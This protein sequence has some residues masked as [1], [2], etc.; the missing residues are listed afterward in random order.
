MRRFLIAAM[1]GAP[2][3]IAGPAVAAVGE[4]E[5]A[6]QDG[7][8]A[9]SA[10]G[11]SLGQTTQATRGRLVPESKVVPAG[12]MLAGDY[13]DNPL[14]WLR[15]GIGNRW[16]DDDDHWRHTRRWDDDNRWHRNHPWYK[17]HDWKKRGR[18]DQHS[19]RWDRDRDWDRDR[20]RHWDDD[21]DDDDRRHRRDWDDDWDDDDRRHGRDWDD[22]RDDRWDD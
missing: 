7:A 11:L 16:D 12:P 5:A 21:W 1:L 22:D 20:R 8:F 2:L 17:R 13:R 10:S 19:R 9:A 14:W 4:T 18:W 3:L 6:T 15:M